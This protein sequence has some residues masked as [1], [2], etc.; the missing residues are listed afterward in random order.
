MV[1]GSYWGVPFFGSFRLSGSGVRKL[2]FPTWLLLEGSLV[3]ICVVVSLT[4]KL[5]TY[6]HI[7]MYTHIHTGPNH[8]EPRSRAQECVEVDLSDLS[9]RGCRDCLQGWGFGLRV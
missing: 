8:H 5:H 7:Y 3:V 4:N 9:R 6:I 2:F 1:I